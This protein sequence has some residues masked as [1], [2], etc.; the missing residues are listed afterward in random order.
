[1]S[2]NNIEPLAQAQA[3]APE[4]STGARLNR[5]YSYRIA[6]TLGA[7]DSLS[8]ILE[9]AGYT[10]DIYKYVDNPPER[11]AAII[12]IE[13]YWPNLNNDLD[14]EAQLFHS[15]TS[16]ATFWGG[17]KIDNANERMQK[18]ASFPNNNIPTEQLK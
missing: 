9:Q 14:L 13:G 15:H 17:I 5:E 4:I 1:M 16:D 3:P 7:I 18:I 11:E 10:V 2:I 8:P 12:A 6:V